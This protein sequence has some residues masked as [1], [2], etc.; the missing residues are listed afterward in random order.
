[1]TI[2]FFL[3]FNTIVEFRFRAPDPPF[4][5][6]FSIFFCF[7][8]NNICVCVGF[9]VAEEKG[10]RKYQYYS[11]AS[12]QNLFVKKYSNFV[13]SINNFYCFTAGH[14][15]NLNLKWPRSLEC[16]P[17]CKMSYSVSITF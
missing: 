9:D 10:L 6:F 11:Q 15:E 5:F 7:K 1:M 12:F 14:I 8:L 2:D 16:L 13:V 3:K 4:S 17:V